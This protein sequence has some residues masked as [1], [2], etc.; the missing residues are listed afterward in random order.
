VLVCSAFGR[1]PRAVS[2]QDGDSRSL[3]PSSRPRGTSLAVLP[4]K[5]FLAPPAPRLGVNQGS[6]GDLPGHRPTRGGARATSPSGARFSQTRETQTG[7]Q[8]GAAAGEFSVNSV[9]KAVALQ[10]AQVSVRAKPP[11]SYSQNHRIVGVGRDL[12]GS[13]SPTP[14][15]SRV[16]QTRLHSTTARRGWNISREGDSTASLGSLGQGSVTLRW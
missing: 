7:Q 1:R 9:S 10:P 15:R 3:S 2:Q 5:A 11:S 12:C 16:T 6:P 14:C 8:T 4:G 13:P